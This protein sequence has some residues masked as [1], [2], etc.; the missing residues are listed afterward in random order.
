MKKNI[1]RAF[2]DSGPA[3]SKEREES[4]KKIINFL[5]K[6]GCNVVQT[7]MGVELSYLD[8]QSEKAATNIYAAKLNDIRDA[9]VVVCE[10][11]LAATTVVFEI[12]EALK[13]RKPVLV[14]C[15]EQNQSTLDAALLGNPSNLLSVEVYN[16]TNLE[17]KIGQ[18]IKRARR[19]IP[20]SRFTVRLTKEM[21]D[22]ISFLKA[23]M[24]CSSKNDVIVKILEQ[25]IREDNDFLRDYE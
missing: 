21:G 3:I 6:H 22:Y 17:E 24:K 11:S 7:V 25:M 16:E 23:K 1:I 12:F 8:K 15:D 20:V 4:N 18:F 19:R 5:N 2:F 13:Q 14:L 10:I 9:D